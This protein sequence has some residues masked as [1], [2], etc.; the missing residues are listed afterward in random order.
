MH[1]STDFVALKE[2][3]ANIR[4]VKLWAG[5]NVLGALVRGRLMSGGLMSVSTTPAREICFFQSLSIVQLNVFQTVVWE[6][7]R[8]SPEDGNT[9]PYHVLLYIPL[10]PRLHSITPCLNGTVFSLKCLAKIGRKQRE[11]CI[12]ISTQIAAQL[13]DAFLAKKRSVIVTSAHHL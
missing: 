7:F 4:R 3:G 6:D 11:V 9:I 13:I 1:F 5:A 10:L 8:I 2:W 12:S